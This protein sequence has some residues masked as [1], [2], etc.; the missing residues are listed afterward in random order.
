MAKSGIRNNEQLKAALSRPMQIVVTYVMDQ[1]SKLNEEIIWDKVYNAYSP[2]EYERTYEFH[3]AWQTE[4][5][6]NIS[7]HTEGK[8]TYDSTVIKPGPRESGQHISVVTGSPSASYLADI[9]YEGLAG[10]VFGFG[11]W[12][13]KRNAYEELIKQIKPMLFRQWITEG[14]R[15]A[16][17]EYKTYVT[18][19]FKGKEI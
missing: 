13:E 17:L 11:P 16:G 5:H 8:L 12:T 2:E 6:G 15:M 4:V 3:R 18:V 9:I 7:G 14:F 19:G 10:N 1:I